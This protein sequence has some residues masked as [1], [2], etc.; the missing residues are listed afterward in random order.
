MSCKRPK[1]GNELPAEYLKIALG[2]SPASKVSSNSYKVRVQD[3]N[4]KKMKFIPKKSSHRDFRITS[5]IDTY[6]KSKEGLN[7][8]QKKIVN[9]RSHIKT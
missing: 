8:K 7:E 5:N 4:L 6:Y 1:I 3:M 9:T 2:A